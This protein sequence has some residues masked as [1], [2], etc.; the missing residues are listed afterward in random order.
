MRAAIRKA[1][2]LDFARHSGSCLPDTCVED[3]PA[4]ELAGIALLITRDNQSMRW[5][6][7]WLQQ[8]GLEVKIATTPDETLGIASATRP[9]VLIVDA[10]LETDDRKSLLGALRKVHGNDVPLIALCNSNADV[11]AAAD[12]EVTDIVRK[13]FDWGL[14]TRRVVKAIKAHRTLG[15][16][17]HANAR[18]DKLAS[19]ATATN[20]E[21]AKAAGMDSLT[22]LPNG[23]KFRSLLHKATAGRSK[24]GS[25]LCLL[26]IGLD[27]FRMVNDAVGYENANILLSQFA[28]RLRRCL[29]DRRVIGDSSSGSVTAIAARLGGARFALLVSKSSTNQIKRVR[30]A[31]EQELRSPFEVAGQSIYLTASIG[32]AI[33]PRDGVNADGLVYYAES[34]MIE[35]QQSGSGFEFYTRP[36]DTSSR[37]TIEMDSML[38]EAVKN[39][40]LTLAYQPITNAM[41][42]EVVA[43]EA[44]LRWHH[45]REGTISPE[46]FVPAAEK[47][48]L[49][50]EIGDF[51]IASACKQ[52]RAWMDSGMQPIRIAINLSLCQLLRGDVVSTVS[53]AL[54]K[55]RLDP[56]MLELEL[57]ERGVLNQRPEVISAVCRLK[58]L[59]VRIS[60]DD[61]GTGQA[62]IGYLK[63]LPIDVIKIDRS[64]VSGAER[65]ARDEAIASGMVAL[66]HRLDANVIAEGVET[67]EQLEMV[68]EWGVQKCQGFYY[69]PAISGRDFQTR[70]S[71]TQ[72]F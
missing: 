62:A 49:M 11:A 72:A 59:G 68:R 1:I 16:L 8:V 35:A 47:T 17:Q 66:A 34:A 52:L 51:V 60:I 63:D 36:E 3:E 27:R 22:R 45:P 10:A 29:R 64:F 18:L 12:A 15:Q 50:S 7:R 30:R 20:R 26:A 32:A 67:R 70:F 65:S 2:S 6:P 38:R 57:S 28:D 42:G 4:A 19:F 23:E 13:P 39:N 55:Y 5:A 24:P 69:C 44:L 21:R 9:S 58:E 56:Q 53:G 61:F 37:Q 41:T 31:I 46:L 71:K 43:A 40:E 54:K 25:E 48:G 14:I 33:Y